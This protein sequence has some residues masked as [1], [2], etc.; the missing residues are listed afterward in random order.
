MCKKSNIKED[1]ASV[2]MPEPCSKAPWR[3]EWADVVK[4]NSEAPF[5]LHVRFN[6]GTSGKVRFEPS[7]FSGVFEV[8][9]DPALFK[10]A[11]VEYG[12]VT[13]PGELDLAPDAMYDEIKK[14]GEWVL[15]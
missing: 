15:S 10:Q 4:V 9:K 7:F 11:Y 1:S 5:V 14:N 6:D 3:V 12:A 2:L 13:W 8:L